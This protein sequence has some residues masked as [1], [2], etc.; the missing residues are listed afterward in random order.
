MA[1]ATKT[2]APKALGEIKSVKIALLIR[3]PRTQSRAEWLP[4]LVK[5]YVEGM[6]REG[7]PPPLVFQDGELLY[8][9][10]GH[11]R[12]AAHELMSLTT[13]TCE[14]RKGSLR[15]AILYACGANEHHG[16]RRTTA[17][18]EKAVGIIL[19]DP[20][21][22]G[23]STSWVAATAKVS[24][25][26]VA[27]LKKEKGIVLTAVVDKDG[28][29]QSSTKVL[30]RDG[31]YYR[32][33]RP[34]QPERA[35][36]D[37]AYDSM[38]TFEHRATNEKPPA[39]ALSV[40]DPGTVKKKAIAGKAD[41][42]KVLDGNKVLVA[43]QF[44]DLF[45]AAVQFDVGQTIISDV[46]KHIQSIKGSPAGKHLDMAPITAA[47]QTIRDTL[48]QARPHIVCTGCNGL[49]CADCGDDGWLTR[50]Q[51]EQVAAEKAG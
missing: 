38:E 40:H 6:R 41:A 29:M 46:S 51:S 14:V 18:K 3:D 49:G 39:A 7:F 32:P 17:D 21:W 12:V 20:E 23:R 22:V 16:L 13:C 43:P 33:P 45:R 2:H 10:D 50:K 37:G 31:K 36:D 5:E 47:I 1:T 8:L 44:E 34:R 28:A 42:E 9:V 11:Y 30:G 25:K 4:E 24:E 15:D 26:L 48:K 35:T 27:R 19:D